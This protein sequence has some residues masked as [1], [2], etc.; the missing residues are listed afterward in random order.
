LRRS[1]PG[2]TRVVCQPGSMKRMKRSVRTARKSGY[3]ARPS[4]RRQRTA[5]DARGLLRVNERLLK[6]CRYREI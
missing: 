5:D 2:D 4:E 6:I 1:A 3:L